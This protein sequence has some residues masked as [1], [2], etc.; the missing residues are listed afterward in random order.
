MISCGCR[1]NL[2]QKTDYDADM[3]SSYYKNAS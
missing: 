2:P 3:A 1:Y